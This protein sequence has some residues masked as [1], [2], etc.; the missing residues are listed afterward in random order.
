MHR[1]PSVQ[2]NS[3]LWK[4][5]RRYI[6]L[7][8]TWLLCCALGLGVVLLLY[9]NLRGS[10]WSMYVLGMIWIVYVFWTEGYLRRSQREGCLHD[11]S[12]LVIFVQIALI[13]LAFSALQISG[14]HVFF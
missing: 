9:A 6:D 7:Y 12:L 14:S 1:P 2:S 8:L 13:L 3:H 10:N 4:Q 11:S 5:V